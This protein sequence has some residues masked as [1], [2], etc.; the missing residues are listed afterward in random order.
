MGR[1]SA[2]VTLNAGLLCGLELFVIGRR[3]VLVVTAVDVRLGRKCR[4]QPNALTGVVPMG[5]IV[6]IVAGD[7]RDVV[8]F[9]CEDSSLCPR[10]GIQ[11]LSFIRGMASRTEGTMGMGLYRVGMR[12]LVPDLHQIVS[13]MQII[14]G[15]DP[16]YR[17]VTG[18]TG[19][20]TDVY[21][22]VFFT[23]GF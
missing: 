23:V 6:R 11:Q 7:A 17:G 2:T 4:T 12:V 21:H 8:L 16:P 19:T 14:L 20:G 5:R 13:G 1:I 18:A 10:L 22:D 9:L 15:Q 3:E